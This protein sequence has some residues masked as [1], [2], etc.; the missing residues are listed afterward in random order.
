MAANYYYTLLPQNFCYGPLVR[1]C[2]WGSRATVLVA[3]SLGLV[4]LPRGR[5]GAQFRV[6]FTITFDGFKGR[7]QVMVALV[8]VLFVVGVVGVEVLAV[9]GEMCQL[10]AVSMLI[11]NIHLHL[12]IK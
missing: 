4:C 12:N 11:F 3:L 1:Y 9:R 8:A 6:L 10:E 5:G 7:N 2:S